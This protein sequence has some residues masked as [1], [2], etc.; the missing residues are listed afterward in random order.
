MNIEELNLSARTYN[1]LKRARIDTVEQLS[2]MDDKALMKIRNFGQRCLGEVRE[3]L[4]RPPMTNADRIRAMT[5]EE[6][7]AEIVLLHTTCELCAKNEMCGGMLG[8]AMC[9]EGVRDW[10]KQPAEEEA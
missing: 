4:S 3:K 9:V 2:Q 1:C 6:L 7:A 10:L 8:I 5:D